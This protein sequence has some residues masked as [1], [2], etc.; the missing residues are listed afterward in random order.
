MIYGSK[1]DGWSFFLIVS[2]FVLGCLMMWCFERIP[3]PLSEY[4]GWIFIAVSLLAFWE[5]ATTKYEIDGSQLVIRSGPGYKAIRLDSIETVERQRGLW[6]WLTMSTGHLRLRY[7]Q[8][9]RTS[10]VIV[11]PA[12]EDHFLGQLKILS[13]W[14]ADN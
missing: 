4:Y 7:R 8:G 11:C 10:S 6:S 13:P 1:S 5:L 12:E 3:L 2:L 14:L 9:L